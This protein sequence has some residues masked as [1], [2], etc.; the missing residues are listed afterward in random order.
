MRS[1][2]ITL[3]SPAKINLTFQVLGQRDDG[4]HE[5]SSRYQAISLGDTLE[6]CLADR[7]SLTCS[8][9][10]ISLE[11]N[12][13]IKAFNLFKAK[14]GWQGS[15]AFRLE[16]RIP[17]QSGLGGGSSNAAT[18]LWALNALSGCCVAES[19][20][21]LWSTA[22]GSDV[23]FFFSSGSAYC[24]GRGEQVVDEKNPYL[25]GTFWIAKPKEG[26]STAAVY[27][28]YA[29]HSFVFQKVES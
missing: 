8:G 7:S 1:E 4:Y 21:A 13:I 11:Q 14:T 25:S 29:R 2:T 15:V 12:L 20:L 19:D 6:V 26:L 24:S 5:I 27:A 16:K 9:L 22:L 28:S 10:Q 3:F 17:L 18:V 23:P